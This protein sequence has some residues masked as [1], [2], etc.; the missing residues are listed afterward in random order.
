MPDAEFA[1]FSGIILLPESK[2][3]YQINQVDSYKQRELIL[4][5]ASKMLIENIL[6]FK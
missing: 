6:K 2:F 3:T 4:L 1:D 5:N